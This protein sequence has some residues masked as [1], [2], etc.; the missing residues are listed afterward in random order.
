[1][2][3]AK[4]VTI[5]VLRA[6]AMWLRAQRLDEATPFG[7]GP[8]AV[9]RAVEHL[10]YVQIDTI[11]VIERCHHHILYSRIP[12]YRRSDLA[13]AQTDEKS[14][15]EYWTHALSYVPTADFRFFIRA[16]EAYRA[17][18]AK[19]FAAETDARA[20]SALLA[21][22]RREG[23]L[24]IRDIDDD[25]LVEKTHPWGSRKPSKGALRFGFYAGD[26]AISRRDGMLKTYEIAARHFGWERRP[27]PASD[28]QTAQYLLARGL[29][30]QSLV[31][32]DSIC[33][34]DAKAKAGVAPLIEAGVKRRTLVPIQMEG[35]KAPALWADAKDLEA[36]SPDVDPGRV[37][38]LSPFDPLVIQ[39]KRLAALFGYEHRFE[40]YAPADKRVLGYFA[41]PVL[42]GDRIVAALDLKT[43]RKAKKLLIQK[44]TW[45]AGETGELRR[46]IE[47]ELGRFERFQ[48]ADD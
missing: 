43:D 38:I 25:V 7:E 22:I 14:V 12:A 17:N 33:Y 3:K 9:R 8:Q 32:L 27:R 48:L 15:F 34:G 6:R 37:H 31:S 2:A 30:A 13:A 18:P 28:A 41:L 5:D 35:A 24:S 39:R 4:P 1:M 44:W 11:N 23:A 16:M 46:A 42:A 29:R 19:A 40:A 26:L 36:P 10:G 45:I 47:D 21:R 20:Y